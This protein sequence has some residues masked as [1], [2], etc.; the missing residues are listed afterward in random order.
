MNRH[1]MRFSH[2]R[3]KD[4]LPLIARMHKHIGYR[5]DNYYNMVDAMLLYDWFLKS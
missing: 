2:M 5:R 1:V 3:I 4:Y